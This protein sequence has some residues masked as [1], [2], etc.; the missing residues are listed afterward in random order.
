MVFGKRTKIQPADALVVSREFSVDRKI[1]KREEPIAYTIY[2]TWFP[3][4]KID[5]LDNNWKGTP[6]EKKEQNPQ[7]NHWTR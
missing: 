5:F 1:C 4:T 7:P 3:K 6:R 2:L